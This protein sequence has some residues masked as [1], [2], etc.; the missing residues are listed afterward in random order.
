VLVLAGRARQRGRDGL[1]L[2]PAADRRRHDGDV[3]DALVRAGRLTEAGAL[4]HPTVEAA[5]VQ[6]IADMGAHAGCGEV[7]LRA[8]TA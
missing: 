7:W 8:A 3:L 1:A 5:L 6:V 4:H 2:L